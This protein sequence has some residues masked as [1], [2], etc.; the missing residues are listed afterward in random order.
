YIDFIF[1][2][3]WISL[4]KGEF[5]MFIK[6]ILDNID[7]LIICLNTN[8][9][10]E[11]TNK[12]FCKILGYE[13]EDLMGKYTPDFIH[14]EDA[15][16]FINLIIEIFDGR[17]TKGI[18][19]VRLKKSD[20]NY[21]WLDFFCI[22]ISEN[23]TPKLV[24]IGKNIEVQKRIIDLE[25]KFVKLIKK[26]DKRLIELKLKKDDLFV[27]LVGDLQELIKVIKSCTQNLLKLENLSPEVSTELK[28]LYKNQLKMEDLIL[29]K[30]ELVF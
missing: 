9:E 24:I 14:P 4:E 5:R 22:K 23:N 30:K 16:A 25:L 28:K 18:I 8:L 10:I 7:D 20:E 13:K 27:Y 29:T 21:I 11:Y 1:I 26:L 12:A 2:M 19:R 6:E 17:E 3:G 15:G